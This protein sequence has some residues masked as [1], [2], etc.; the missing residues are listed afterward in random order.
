MSRRYSR[1]IFFSLVASIARCQEAPPLLGVTQLN[2]DN[3]FEFQVRLDGKTWFEQDQSFSRVCVTKDGKT[4]STLDASLQ[5]RN[6][7]RHQA[8]DGLG[9]YTSTVYNWSPDA[10]G[11]QT[12]F[13]LYSE[14]SIIVF[15]QRFHVQTYHFGI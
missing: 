4:Y 9:S 7:S 10:I 1:L 11:F 12:Q 14:E 8:S 6:L 13:R 3:T 5:P 2:D 15:T